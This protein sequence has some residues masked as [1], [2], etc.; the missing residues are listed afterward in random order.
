MLRVHTTLKVIK[1]TAHCRVVSLVPS[2]KYSLL[3]NAPTI[4]PIIGAIII[5][6]LLTCPIIKS[7]VNI[8]SNI[9]AII[10]F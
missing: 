6:A 5:S 8:P 3:Y 7:N 2:S 4:N 10:I 9:Y 1:P